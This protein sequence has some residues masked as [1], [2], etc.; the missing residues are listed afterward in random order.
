MSDKYKA[1]KP[2]SS[3]HT[4]YVRGPTATFEHS[5][6]NFG[7]FSEF[8]KREDAQ[9]AAELCNLAYEEGMKAARRI[10]RGALGL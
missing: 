9:R 2:K 6:D 5:F 3:D 10:M 8:A 7:T 4:H 1:M